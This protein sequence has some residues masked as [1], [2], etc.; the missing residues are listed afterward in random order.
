MGGTEFHAGQK[1]SVYFEV[2]GGGEA[3]AM[4]LR[5]VDRATSEERYDSG[6]IDGAGTD[7]A[8][9]PIALPLPAAGMPAGAYTV[10]VRVTRGKEALTRTANFDVK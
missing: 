3:T 9:I 1:G 8:M 10:E 4:R 6:L 7:G 2:Y 5:I